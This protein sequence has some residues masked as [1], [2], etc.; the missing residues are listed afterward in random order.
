MT[1]EELPAWFHPG[2]E[3]TAR[4]VWSR[5]AE[6]GDEQ[7]WAQVAREGAAAALHAV[8]RGRSDI[9]PVPGRWRVRL[10]QTDPRRDLLALDRVQGRLVIP[11]DPEWP[12]GLD[13]LGEK[14]PFCLWVR[15]R[16]SL[17]RVCERSIAIVGARAATHYGERQAGE[18]A[19]G[20]GDHGLT[21]VSGAAYGVDAGT[22]TVAVLA[23]GVDRAYPRGNERLIEWIG[24]EGCLVTEV[25]PGSSPTRWRFLERNR[26]IAAMTRGTVVVEAAWRSGAL[27]TAHRALDLGRPVGAVPGP[28][29]SAMSA[30][31]HRLLRQG[32][33]CITDAGE[34]V[35]LVSAI[36]EHPTAEPVPP[37]ADHDGLSPVDLRVLDALPLVRAAELS[38]V[39]LAAGLEQHDV[40]AAAGR[41]ELLRLA[42]R[43]GRGWRRRRPDPDRR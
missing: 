14:R 33:T 25:P 35:E 30:G 26:M 28:V 2:D 27:G 29:S 22:P 23:C 41:L 13:A 10:P 7:A 36:G 16:L 43:S 5:L 39:A 1:G 18:I 24:D 37:R 31:C 4:A 20:A 12:S 21:V 15:G 11:G 17:A 3:R 34:A 9:G 19:A 38:S 40:E 32:A 42:E 8:I 6:P